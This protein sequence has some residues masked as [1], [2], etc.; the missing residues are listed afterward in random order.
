MRVALL[1]VG[2]GGAKLAAGIQ[3]EIGPDLTVIANTGDDIETLG[4]HVSP[5]PDLITFR[6]AGVI[7]WPAH[8]LVANDPFVIASTTGALPTG[9]TVDIPLFVKTV[10]DADNF[11]SRYDTVMRT[12]LID[13]GNGNWMSGFGTASPQV[14]FGQAGNAASFTCP[15]HGWSFLNTGKLRAVPWPDGYACDFKDAKFNV[16]QVP[17]QSRT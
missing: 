4:V 1:A 6:L 9:A 7:G 15:Y 10:I 2:T 14:I 17:A 11:T 3:E 5:D 13:D 16:A 12:S 8:G